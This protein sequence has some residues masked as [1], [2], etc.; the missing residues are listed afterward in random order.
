MDVL[1]HVAKG[2]TYPSPGA[3]VNDWKNAGAACQLNQLVL[4]CFF[5][6]LMLDVG[7]LGEF[8]MTVREIAGKSVEVNEEGFM[9]NYKEWDE[10]IA[11]EFA[12]EFGIDELTADHWNVINFCRNEYEAT[13]EVPTLRRITKA[14]GVPTK[15]L[16]Q[17]FPKGPAKKVAKISG[18]TKPTGCI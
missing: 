1:E 4:Y 10:D 15:A 11:L 14:G 16:Y 18:L 7:Y 5:F 2:E 8:K 13:G 17:L 3:Y 9:I 6:K 12:H